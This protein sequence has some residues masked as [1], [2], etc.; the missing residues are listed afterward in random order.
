MVAGKVVMLGV[1]RVAE[2]EACSDVA[3]G[4]H[5]F[6][7]IEVLC[8]YQSGFLTASDGRFGNGSTCESTKTCC[9]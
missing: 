7:G 6:I 5:C 2:V 1:T 8:C 9:T 4:R 3:V